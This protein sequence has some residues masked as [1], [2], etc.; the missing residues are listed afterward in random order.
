MQ[1]GKKGGAAK[2]WPPSESELLR[3]VPDASSA[4]G[5]HRQKLLVQHRVAV[6]EL[7]HQ[8]HPAVALV[9]EPQPLPGAF[10]EHR[11]LRG[12]AD[13]TAPELLTVSG[14]VHSA[15]VPTT[16]PGGSAGPSQAA[17]VGAM[18]CADPLPDPDEVAALLTGDPAAAAGRLDALDRHARA[19]MLAALC[20]LACRDR[21]AVSGIEAVLRAA[22]FDDRAAP[23]G[24]SATL[25][26]KLALRFIVRSEVT[27]DA[28]RLFAA[29]RDPLVARLLA[30]PAQGLGSSKVWLDAEAMAGAVRS[31]AEVV[32]ALDG[33]AREIAV[34]LCED[35]TDLDTDQIL[36]AAR[37]LRTRAWR[38]PGVPGGAPSQHAPHR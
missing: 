30:G 27:D 4:V 33:E 6:V 38:L 29:L 3:C 37:A 20:H 28:A 11:H 13:E 31:A 1:S 23:R 12:R 34:A 16:G 8:M 14:K 9:G 5:G 32:A 17:T 15:H 25:E 22:A 21:S 18:A 10:H 36:A 26:R 35:G 19:Q 7:A 24:P 2:L